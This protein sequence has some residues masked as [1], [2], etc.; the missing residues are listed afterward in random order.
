[1]GAGG[2]QGS[3]LA[4]GSLGGAAGG[5]ASVAKLGRDSPMLN[6]IL[7]LRILVLLLVSTMPYV[8]RVKNH[9]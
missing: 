1:V 4:G 2:S 5:R 7:Q 9:S 8:V 3:V 6:N